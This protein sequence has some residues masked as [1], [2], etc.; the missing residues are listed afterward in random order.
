MVAEWKPP[1]VHIYSWD[2]TH[3]Q[4]LGRVHLP[5]IYAVQCVDDDK[6]ILATGEGIFIRSLQVYRVGICFHK[7]M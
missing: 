3:I 4:V 5:E 7:S 6:L 1:A 2:A